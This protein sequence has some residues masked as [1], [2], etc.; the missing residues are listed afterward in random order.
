M[1]QLRASCLFYLGRSDVIDIRVARLWLLRNKPV[2]QISL[3][4]SKILRLYCK[5]ASPASQD[6]KGSPPPPPAVA[7]TSCQLT[8]VANPAS[9]PLFTSLQEYPGNKA[10]GSVH[11]L[12]Y[13]GLGS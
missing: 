11:G 8:D 1:R 12:L 10:A 5:T 3:C 2:R 13:L 4:S 9:P 6:K 7:F